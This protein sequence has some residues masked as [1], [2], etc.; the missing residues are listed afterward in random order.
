MPTAL[1]TQMTNISYPVYQTG[2]SLLATYLSSQSPSI[3]VKAAPWDDETIDWRLFDAIVVRSPHDYH[4]RGN[5]FRKWLQRLM[6]LENLSRTEFRE[7][8][9]NESQLLRNKITIYNEPRTMLWNMNKSYLKELS[10]K[11]L[12]EGVVFPK[13]LWFSEEKVAELMTGTSG[14]SLKD[15]LAKIGM[16]KKAVVKPVVGA[17]KSCALSVSVGQSVGLLSDGNER[18]GAGIAPTQSHDISVS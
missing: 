1:S 7:S 12:P 9:R 17:G 5:Q 15:E 8:V 11:G 2:D 13:T 4:K 3:T 6:K 10:S 16:G 14:F 18:R